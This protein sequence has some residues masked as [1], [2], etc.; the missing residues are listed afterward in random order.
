MLEVYKIMDELS[1]SGEFIAVVHDERVAYANGVR[2]G[3]EYAKRGF[4]PDY[5]EA[6]SFR[7][8][9][10]EGFKVGYNHYLKKKQQRS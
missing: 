1:D 9:F 8:S 7:E 10:V 2:V 6:R 3:I 4:K 5:S